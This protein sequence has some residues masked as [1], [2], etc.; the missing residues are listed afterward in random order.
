MGAEN[1]ARE[2][3]G[4]MDEI[5]WYKV[6]DISEGVHPETGPHGY[7]PTGQDRAGGWHARRR[8][9]GP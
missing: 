3:D 7:T 4:L 2:V 8:Q 5:S 6:Y 9:R 1:I